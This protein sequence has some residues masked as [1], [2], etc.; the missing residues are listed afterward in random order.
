MCPFAF[1]FTCVSVHYLVFIYVFIYSFS[2]VLTGSFLCAS[3][4]TFVRVHIYFDFMYFCMYYEVFMLVFM[5]FL[6]FY[7]C[8]RTFYLFMHP[9]VF[10][11]SSCFIFSPDTYNLKMKYYSSFI[12]NSFV[13]RNVIKLHG[14]IESTPTRLKK[15][16]KK[17]ENKKGTGFKKTKDEN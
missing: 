3:S 4:Y 12:F 2:C 8:P 16:K 9:H 14:V 11:T 13:A 1:F 15:E 10:S 7:V 17:T 6:F 5:Y